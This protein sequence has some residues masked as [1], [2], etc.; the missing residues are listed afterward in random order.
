MIRFT[1]V[2][3]HAPGRFTAWASDL[4]MRPGEWPATL[5]TAIGN[6]QPLL[7]AAPQINREGDVEFV[8]YDQQLGCVSVDIFND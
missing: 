1:D 3:E 2:T 6:C 8:R 5:P 4:G 7:R